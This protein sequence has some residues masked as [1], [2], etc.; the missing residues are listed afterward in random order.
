MSVVL[1]FF[2]PSF[3]WTP[4]VKRIE[5]TPPIAP[6]GVVRMLRCLVVLSH[7]LRV[8]AVFDFGLGRS[9][10]TEAILVF[11]CFLCSMGYEPLSLT[12]K[13]YRLTNYLFLQ[14]LGVSSFCLYR[15]VGFCG[16]WFFKLKI[17]SCYRLCGSV[18]WLVV[19]RVMWSQAWWTFLNKCY[20]TLNARGCLWWTRRFLCLSAGILWHLHSFGH[21]WVK[22][23]TALSF[24]NC[25]NLYIYGEFKLSRGANSPDSLRHSCSL[26]CYS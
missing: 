20:Y 8:K 14:D 3:S 24:R 2:F 11:L 16:F 23:V 10:L 17:L 15:I 18:L 7:S 12:S 19:C 13:H 4:G 1:G 21:I 6:F 9:R 5:W 26:I 22:N 25:L